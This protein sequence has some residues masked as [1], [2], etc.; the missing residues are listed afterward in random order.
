MFYYK[1]LV[2]GL[3]QY[4]ACTHA[5]VNQDGLIPITKEEYEKVVAELVVL[6]ASDLEAPKETQE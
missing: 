1:K 4:H 2:D 3:F 5:P 6:G